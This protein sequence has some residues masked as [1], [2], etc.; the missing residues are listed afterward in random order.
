MLRF[1]LSIAAALSLAA[2]SLALAC[3]AHADGGESA[4]A[5]AHKAENG[6]KP[7]CAGEKG[8]EACACKN[9]EACAAKNEGKGCACA[10]GKKEQTAWRDISVDAL[11]EIHASKGKVSVYDVNPAELR[12]KEGVIPGAILLGSSSEYDVS[13]L[14]GD[15]NEK[16]VF[17]CANTRC[18][19]SHRAAERA[20]GAGYTD[21]NVLPAGIKGWKEAG[22]ATS[23]PQS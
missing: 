15:K 13:L 11:S 12:A 5:C 18:T 10:K 3:P 17:Y 8:E 6:K 2:P 16:L 23:K 22:K 1:M 19:A 20:L 7:C 14:P 21:V 4:C 9:K